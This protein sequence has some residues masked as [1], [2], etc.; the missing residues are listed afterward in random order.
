MTERLRPK[1]EKPANRTFLTLVAVDLHAEVAGVPH[2]LALL[3]VALEAG[4]GLPVRVEEPDGL[5][6]QN[7]RRRISFARVPPRKR[8]CG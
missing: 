3:F 1:G 4:P 8:H 6:G 2:V 5:S 7:T